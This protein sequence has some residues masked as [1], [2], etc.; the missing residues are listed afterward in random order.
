MAAP[1]GARNSHLRVVPPS[2]DCSAS[3][4]KGQRGSSLP[5]TSAG[6]LV[7]S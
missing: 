2:A 1:S 3:T 7:M 6:R 5:L 4:S